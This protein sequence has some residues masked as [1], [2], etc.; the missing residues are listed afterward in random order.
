MADPLIPDGVL[1]VPLKVVVPHDLFDDVT[2]I[3]EWMQTPPGLR[4][5]RPDNPEAKR[6]LERAI[7][8]WVRGN[9]PARIRDAKVYV[10]VWC[11]KTPHA[12]DEEHA[13]A[14]RVV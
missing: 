3:V 13:S 2:A 8:E 12:P 9:D 11:A 14:M 5:P 6:V 7:S 1:M 4:G 10:S